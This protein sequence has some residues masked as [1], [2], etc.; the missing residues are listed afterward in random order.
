MASPNLL[1]VEDDPE[2][3]DYLRR[4]LTYESYRVRVATSAEAGF[5][6][7]HQYHPDLM[8]LDVM[9]PGLDGM[10]ACRRLRA[11]GYHCPVLMLTARDA[12]NDRVL[13]LDAGADDYLVKPFVFDE[14]LA[15]LR[16]LL[17]RANA[18]GSV[19][20]FAD[21]ELNTSL[22]TAHRHG[23]TIPLS[24]I[25]YELLALF[26]AHPQQVLTRNSIIEEVWG[27]E[28]TP[29]DNMLDVYVSRL[30]RKLGIPLLIHT[31]HSVG[32]VLKEGLE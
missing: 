29:T 18:A 21:L 2:F 7:M 3:A 26:L 32:Y 25:E 22:R 17:R 5:E 12:I 16:A 4:G 9:L 31:L 20:T 24:R 6:Q 14:L 28:A 23:H 27:G 19:V 8:I 15:R 10:E 13:G 30:R 1:I 11:S